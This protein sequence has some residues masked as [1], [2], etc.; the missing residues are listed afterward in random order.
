MKTNNI[1]ANK[2]KPTNQFEQYNRLRQEQKVN[3]V[4]FAAAV[5][6]LLMIFDILCMYVFGG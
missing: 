5:V 6:A 4:I 1:W 2:F 3:T